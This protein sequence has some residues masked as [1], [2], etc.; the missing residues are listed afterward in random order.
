MIPKGVLRYAEIPRDIN[1]RKMPTSKFGH[2]WPKTMA[3]NVGK[4]SIFGRNTN[5]LLRASNRISVSENVPWDIFRPP[6]RPGTKKYPT[7]DKVRVRV[8]Q[9]ILC[10]G[11]I[12]EFKMIPKGVLRHAEIP[13][14]ISLLRSLFL[15]GA[16]RD[17]PKN[18]CEGDYKD[19]E[20]FL[21]IG[22]SA[23][24]RRRTSKFWPYLRCGTY[25]KCTV[26]VIIL[27]GTVKKLASSAF[28]SAF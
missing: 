11:V 26:D 8:K 14:D 20:A 17:S 5:I 21:C 22:V 6:K 16:L 19:I 23:T 25:T 1:K 10:Q 12:C 27:K 13:K 24:A 28:L 18:G 3:K 2:F 9:K 15:G 7:K 4:K